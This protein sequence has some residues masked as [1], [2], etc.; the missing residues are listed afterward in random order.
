MEQG[1]DLDMEPDR[2]P[3]YRKDTLAD[4]TLELVKRC[5]AIPGMEEKYQAWLREREAQKGGE[6]K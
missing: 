4:A 1:S 2:M 5:F 3:Q 6:A